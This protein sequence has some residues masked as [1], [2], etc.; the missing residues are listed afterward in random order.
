MVFPQHIAQTRL[1]PDM[2]LWS[3]AKKI[4][5][6]VELTV[7]WES[8]MEWAYERKTTRYSD[9]QSDCTERGWTCKIYPV[10]VG[11]RGFVGQSTIK[12]LSAIGVA[13]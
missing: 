3:D 5:L 8:N 13:P 11:C 6:I 7:P 2:V 4:V 1:R 10:E 9:L 12:F